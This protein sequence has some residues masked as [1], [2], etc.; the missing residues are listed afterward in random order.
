[1]KN[2]LNIIKVPSQ[3]GERFLG[4]KNMHSVFK[5]SSYAQLWTGNL[6]IFTPLQFNSYFFQMCL[7][8]MRKKCIFT[9]LDSITFEQ[10]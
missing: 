1:M 7:L 4:V 10:N 3:Q 5:Q 8:E 6:Q 9:L 2:A